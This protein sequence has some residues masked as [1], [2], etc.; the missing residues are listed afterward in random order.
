MYNFLKYAGR[1]HL[2]E[3][4]HFRGIGTTLATL[5]MARPIFSPNQNVVVK[6]G[7]GTQKGVSLKAQANN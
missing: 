5:V 6:M 4:F 1:L 3:C 2:T 7:R